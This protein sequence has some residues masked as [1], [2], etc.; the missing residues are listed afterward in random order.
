MSAEVGAVGFLE[1]DDF[2]LHHGFDPF[3]D[4][5]AN[6]LVLFHDEA[7][8]LW[9]VRE[10]HRLRALSAV[11]EIAVQVLILSGSEFGSVHLD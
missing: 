5:L 6:L 9:L 3:V 2:I 11:P 8:L 4:R 1:A 10:G 7:V